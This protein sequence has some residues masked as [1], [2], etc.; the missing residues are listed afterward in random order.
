M[1]TLAQEFAI[2]KIRI[3]SILP[4]AIKHPSTAQL[5][6]TRS[7]RKIDDTDSYKRIGEPMTSVKQLYGCAVMRATM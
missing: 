1:K 5:G 7:L 3:N 4:G 6:Y 2:K